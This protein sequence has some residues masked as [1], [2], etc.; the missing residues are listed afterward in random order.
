M[1]FTA[2]TVVGALSGIFNKG[3]LAGIAL[4]FQGVAWV[5]MGHMLPEQNSG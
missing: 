2:S 5:L 3:L 1:T 4:L